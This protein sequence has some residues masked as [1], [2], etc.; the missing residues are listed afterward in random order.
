MNLGEVYYLSAK[1]RD[2]RYADRV[3][4]GLRT[5]LTILSATDDVVMFAA[6]L[7]GR[8]AISYADG[9][10]AATAI[11]NNGVLVTGDP[12][13]RAVSKSE[14]ELRIDWIGTS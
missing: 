1:S 14:K 3:L 2:S 7:K 12:E 10:A 11:L 13:L 9:F 6:K 4:K 5:R 8:Y